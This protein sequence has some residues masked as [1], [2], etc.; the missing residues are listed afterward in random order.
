MSIEQLRQLAEIFVNVAREEDA[1]LSTLCNKGIFYM[2]EIAYAY[3]C[4]KAVIQRCRAL[5]YQ[6][7]IWRRELQVSEAGPTDLVLE[8]P[9]RRVLVEF[10]MVGTMAKYL[11]DFRKLANSA[12]P[13]DEAIF[14][15]LLD[16]FTHKLPD[17]RIQIIEAESSH[18][19]ES[20]LDETPH[21]STHPSRNNKSAMSC[22]IAAWSVS[23]E[24]RY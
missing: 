3:A 13:N 17:Q 15:V 16:E 2:P 23:G 14:C 1:L 8:F 10:K 4:G 22:S 9:G 5:D 21:F 12:G 6:E 19:L 18:R 20:L 24:A 7:I 11:A